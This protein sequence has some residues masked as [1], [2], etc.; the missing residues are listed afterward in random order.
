[1]GLSPH[2]CA[3]IVCRA[4]GFSQTQVLLAHPYLHSIMRRDT[5]G[6]EAGVMLLLD[7]L[8]NFSRHLIGSHRGATQD[9]PLVLTSRILPGEVDDM[10][11]D[12]DI[13]WHYPL[14]LYQAAEQYAAPS[15]DLGICLVKSQLGTPGQ[16]VGFGFTHDTTSLN[17]GVRCCGYKLLPTFQ[18]KVA[19]QMRL[20]E[21]L[22]CVDASDVARLVIER[23]FIRDIIGNLGKFSMQQFR[24]VSCNA[25]YRRPP[26]SGTCLHCK[27]KLLFTISEGSV[28]KY[29]APSL[30]LAATYDVPA[31]LRQTLA[32]TQQRI[33]HV[34]GKDAEK[35][36]GLG[37]WFG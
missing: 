20:A 18:Q 11:F 8:L 28:V 34:F 23:H 6:D 13:A 1:M 24:C 16:Y 27:G 25:K 31:Y 21:K 30:S 12:M 33:I 2:T 26:L 37:R 5:D 36:E 32:L 15:A 19:V 14:S 22:R 29:L 4:I 9:E 7:A 17:A 3:G 35:Q 10:V